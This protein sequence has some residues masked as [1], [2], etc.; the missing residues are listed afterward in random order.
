MQTAPLLTE[1][2]QQ[3]TLAYRLYA[4]CYAPIALL[5][6]LVVWRGNIFRH[7]TWFARAFQSSPGGRHLDVATGDGSLTGLAYRIAGRPRL[8]ALICLDLSPDMLQKATQRIQAMVPLT[9]VT[10]DIVEPPCL[11]PFDTVTCFGGLMVFSDMVE[12]LRQIRKLLKPGASLYGSMLLLPAAPWRQKMVAGYIEKG[13]Q[14]CVPREDEFL[15]NLEQ[16]GLRLVNSDRR[17]DNLLF[18]AMQREDCV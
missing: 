1:R 3:I 5:V 8:E 10:G 9:I 7:I 14:T 4:K 11:E 18:Q 15:A 12:A 17:G 13:Y 16:A 2:N 6:F